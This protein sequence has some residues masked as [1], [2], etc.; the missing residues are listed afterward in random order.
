MSLEYDINSIESIYKYAK[1]LT[2]KSLSEVIHLPL[3]AGNLKSRGN[4]GTL[5]ERYFFQ[6]VPPNLHQPDFD[7][8]GLELKTTGL[9]KD[10][11]GNYKAKERL[12]LTMIH[13]ESIVEERWESSTLLMKCKLMLILFYLYQKDIP[14]IDLKFPIDPLL[15][16]MP[17]TDIPIIK[18]D[19][20]FIRQKVL[21]GRAHELSEGD[22]F[23][24][25]ACRKGSGGEDESLQDQPFSIIQA[26]TR[27]FSFKQSYLNKLISGHIEETGLLSQ[28]LTTS[29]DEATYEKLKP[30][31]G[32][33]LDEISKTIDYFRTSSNQKGFKH[34][35]LVRIL[36]NGM[37]SV[38]ELEKAG[39]EMKTI[40]LTNTGRPK[41][42]MSFPGFR[43]MDIIHEEWADSNFNE[44]IEKKFLLI[45]FQLDDFGEER[46]IK[47]GYWNMPYEDRLEAR[48]VWEETKRRVAVNAKDLPK[49]GESY[50]AHVRPKAR[51]GNDKIE[52]PQGDMHVKQCFW[53]NQSYLS[54]VVLEQ[55]K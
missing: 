25:G 1:L 17:P 54:K 49:V 13:Y 50:L 34:D 9:V 33:S 44:K 52:T 12:V 36:S 20:E 27:A 4:L 51:N 41:E 40:T 31:F 18:S 8:A 16:D 37:N 47:A 15:Y 39:I 5:I 28:S 7:K 14:P 21:D 38:P 53:L 35:L 48:R 43:F 3:D 10:S 2:G 30:F 29:L 46:L 32:K 24:L 23:Y 55:I 22:T 11:R 45:V 6:H 26:K 42:H 19:W